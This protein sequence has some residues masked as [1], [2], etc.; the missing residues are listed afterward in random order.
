MYLESFYIPTKES[1]I[2]R[3]KVAAIVFIGAM[4]CIVLLAFFN[5][6]VENTPSNFINLDY[7]PWIVSA[8]QKWTAKNNKFYI[9]FQESS[10][11]L[12]VFRDNLLKIKAIMDEGRSYTVGINKFADLTQEEFASRYLK[13][14]R[15]QKRERNFVTLNTTNIPDAIDWRQKNAVTPVMDQGLC[16]SCWAFS[17]TGAIEGLVAIKTGYLAA[18][19][20]QN[21]VDCSRPYGNEGCMSGITDFAYRYI[22]ENGIQS[23]SDYPYRGSEQRCKFDTTKA[24][25]TVKGYADVPE[26]N[27]DQLAAAIANQ[28]VAV[29]IEGYQLV[30]QFYIGGVIDTTAC[31]TELDHDVLA[32]GYGAEGKQQYF[33]VKNSWGSDWGERGYA[34]IAR[35]PGK[36]P[37]ICGI[38]EMASY[39]TA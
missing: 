15:T 32:I 9:T 35:H 11:R 13:P 29:G 22:V 2:T 26:N 27:Q 33:I 24:D 36:G 17:A 7:E 14:K 16:T 8:F 19:S 20:K 28:P 31:G 38:A 34:R 5:S 6:R 37:G 30:F 10:Y 12:R 39:P 25:H 3:G 4:A 18:L 1:S 23:E 21:L